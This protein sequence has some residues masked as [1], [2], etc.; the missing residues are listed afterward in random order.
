MNKN[1]TVGITGSIWSPSRCHCHDV[2]LST[3]EAAQSHS[4][5]LRGFHRGFETFMLRAVQQNDTDVTEMNMWPALDHV[6]GPIRKWS[7]TLSWSCCP[8]DPE[9]LAACTPPWTWSPCFGSRGWEGASSHCILCI[10]HWNRVTGRCFRIWWKFIDTR[11]VLPWMLS[12]WSTWTSSATDQGP[13]VFCNVLQDVFKW[14][15]L[16]RRKAR[17]YSYTILICIICNYIYKLLTVKY[18]NY[19]LYNILQYTIPQTSYLIN[20]TTI[21]EDWA[22]PWFCC[23]TIVWVHLLRIRVWIHGSIKFDALGCTDHFFF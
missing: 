21:V 2:G 14:F 5:P 6:S 16:R 3:C 20:L 17:L 19:I 10:Q 1:V 7:S 12:E 18:Y 11:S 15:N 13:G 9:N 22:L 4:L 23:I 8:P